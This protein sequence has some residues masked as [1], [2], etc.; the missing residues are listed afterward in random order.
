M[1]CIRLNCNN[2]CSKNIAS[3]SGIT[4]ICD[5]CFGILFDSFQKILK[6]WPEN[7]ECKFKT[8]GKEAVCDEYNCDAS[9]MRFKVPSY[10]IYLDEETQEIQ[11]IYY[12]DEL[13]WSLSLQSTV[14]EKLDAARDN[15]LRSLFI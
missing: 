6:N 1:G 4:T 11:E 8:I 7:L 3:L 10:K 12:D 9:C 5:Q 14:E 2:P 15:N 13:L